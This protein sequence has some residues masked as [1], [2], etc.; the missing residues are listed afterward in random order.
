VTPNPATAASLPNSLRVMGSIGRFLL[1]RR[2]APNS[3]DP[4]FHGPRA[5]PAYLSGVSWDRV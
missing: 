5:N 3:M 1:Y 2:V 4:R